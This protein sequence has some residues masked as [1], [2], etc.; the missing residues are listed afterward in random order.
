[1]N[2]NI[3][4]LNCPSCGGTLN[5]PDNLGVAH[6]VYCGAKILITESETNKDRQKIISYSELCESALKAQNY[7]E[8]FD[9]CNKVLE[10]DSKN[11]D[12]W[13]NKATAAFWM[14]TGNNNRYD[15]AINYLDKANQIDPGNPKAQEV[16]NE[17]TRKQ[18]LWLHKLGSDEVQ[19]ALEIFKIYNSDHT[20]QSVAIAKE[21]CQEYFIKSANYFLEASTLEPDNMEI[22]SSIFETVTNITWISWSDEF[23]NK[24]KKYNSY[25]SLQQNL[26]KKKQALEDLPKYKEDLKQAEIDLSKAKLEKGLFARM[27]VKDV[28]KRIKQ[29]NDQIVDLQRL[30]A[31]ND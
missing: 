21:K 2:Q 9:Y 3:I 14:T 11:V 31:T 28:E 17:L 1:M 7:Q 18:A 25:V 13:I 15:E 29:L 10:I 12:A 4:S 20:S 27:K 5:I 24:A 30:I 23:I 8:A 26:Q 6:C 19:H 22:L 16:K